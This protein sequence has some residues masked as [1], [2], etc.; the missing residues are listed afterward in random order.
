MSTARYGKRTPT[1]SGVTMSSLQQISESGLSKVAEAAVGTN[2]TDR[3]TAMARALVGAVPGAGSVLAEVITAA[4][5]RQ[6]LDRVADF[7]ILLAKEVEKL[8]ATDKL[9][10]SP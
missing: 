2:A 10:A 6:R 3:I 4:V 9:A 8:S 1:Q 7:V 5:P